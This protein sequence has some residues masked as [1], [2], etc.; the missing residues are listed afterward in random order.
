MWIPGQRALSTSFADPVLT[1]KELA[2]ECARGAAREQQAAERPFIQMRPTLGFLLLVVFTQFVAFRSEPGAALAMLFVLPSVLLVQ[3]LPRALVG[4]ALGRSCKIV[5][6]AAGGQTEL[7]GAPLVGAAYLAFSAVGSLANVILAVAILLL[8]QRVSAGAWTPLAIL[9][10]CQAAWGLGQALP[11]IPFRAGLASARRMQPTLRLAHALLSVLFVSALS[12]VLSNTAWGFAFVPVL[13]LAALASWRHLADV[14]RESRDQQTGV[15]A[16]AQHAADH[17]LH[18]DAAGAIA[19]AQRGLALAHSMKL[20]NRLNKTLAWAAIA[21]PDP[22]LAHQALERLP[23]SDLD[24]HLVAA[25]LS[26]CNRLD[27]AARLL[28]EARTHGHR[29]AET[30]KLAVELLYRS[31]KDAAARALAEADRQLLS[32]EDWQAI[33]GT[34]GR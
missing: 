26:C 28:E 3:E 20:R 30:T 33:D 21:K 34:I 23:A 25:Y 15:T 14:Y 12:A 13:V 18:D 32:A 2:L 17:A 19:A 11:V 5:L 1:W 29:S 16:I 22:I 4:R 31:G 6:S 9:A 24:L 7:I 10:G 27:E 8:H